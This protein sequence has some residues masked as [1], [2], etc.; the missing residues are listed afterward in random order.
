M[1][2]FNQKINKT[3]SSF[4]VSVY[5]IEDQVEE[6]ANK[7]KQ[8]LIDKIKKIKIFNQLDE[9]SSMLN[10][11][12][13]SPE[14]IEKFKK[15]LKAICDP[16]KNKIS[17]FDIRRSYVTEF[18]SQLLLEKQ[19]NCIFYDQAD[20]R[21]NS[22]AISINKHTPGIDV[23][24]LHID[25]SLKFAVCEVKASK[26]AI[27]CTETSGLLSDVKKS[28]EVS[29]RRLTKE[30]LNYTS[31]LKT[32][33]NDEL[34]AKV[35]DFLLNILK[36][37]N[38]EEF[39]ISNVIFF[40]FLIRNNAAIVGNSDISDFDLFAQEDFNQTS[41]KGIIWSFNNDIDSF[42]EKIWEEA[43]ENV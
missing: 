36:M 16:Y 19:Y 23:V 33:D 41:I 17:T 39:V 21:L 14:F 24:G 1:P 31:Y 42:C 4:E 30:I 37:S 3:L 5:E 9:V 2:V 12:N 40:P 6:E 18:M 22:D 15:D 38:D 8:Y 34:M 26:S 27:P 29:N 32:D 10:V 28:M 11:P 43:V 20:K 25:E 35:V 7:L 13:V